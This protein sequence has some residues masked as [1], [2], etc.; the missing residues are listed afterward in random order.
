VGNTSFFVN[1]DGVR[2]AA[3]K[4]PRR[5][6][7][8]KVKFSYP[9]RSMKGKN[10]LAGKAGLRALAYMVNP[11]RVLR[12]LQFLMLHNPLYRDHVVLDR[13]AL[14]AI[15]D[16]CMSA[17]GG[18]DE[19]FERF[20]KGDQMDTRFTTL[21]SASPVTPDEVAG[22]LCEKYG[23]VTVE[24]V[25]GPVRP[26]EEP[27][28]LMQ[29]FPSHF[30]LGVGGDYKQYPVPLTISE[31]FSHTVKFGDPRFAKDYRYV[32]MMTNIKALE[33]GY[34]SIASMLKGK[35]LKSKIDGSVEDITEQLLEGYSKVVRLY[36]RIL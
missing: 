20:A 3:T 32:F 29:A 10:T 23:E 26:H 11:Q 34:K 17:T 16:M 33:A 5:L 27:T 14:H 19:L 7:E 30:P 24:R 36:E 4:L 18:L 15:D 1:W 8:A 31:M 22:V 28:L 13:E 12:A 35:V 25:G 6:E 21:V 2:Q 9:E